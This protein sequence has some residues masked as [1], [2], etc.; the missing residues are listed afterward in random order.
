MEI[1]DIEYVKAILDKGSVTKAAEALYITQPSLSTYLKNMN[2]RLGFDVFVQHGKKFELSYLGEEFLKYGLEILKIKGDFED[3]LQIIQ[4]NQFG[5]LKIAI[6]LLRSSYLV[7]VL[8]PKFKK[9]YPNVEIILNESSSAKFTQLLENGDVDI[10]LM[11]RIETNQYLHSEQIKAEEMLIALPTKHSLCKKIAN[12]QNQNFPIMDLNL[13][14]NELFILHQ[15]DQFSRQVS[16]QIFAMHHF[17]PKHVLATRNIETASNLVA[18]NSGVC[19][20][21]SSHSKHIMMTDKITFFS[22]KI[23]FY[24]DLIVAYRKHRQLPTYA[25]AFIDICKKSI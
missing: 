5:R 1:K 6:P 21:N 9:L 11:N 16:D 23:P 15:P 14:E 17:K 8:L 20:I 7:P 10:A 18:N 2:S 3:R 4:N 25:Q 13:L 12:N 19:F 24:V 22:L